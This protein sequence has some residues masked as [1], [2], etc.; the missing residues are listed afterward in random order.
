MSWVLTTDA[1]PDR[2]RGPSW[3]D[4]VGR[5]L[6]PVA[7]TPRD[8][9]FD[10]GITTDALGCLRISRIEAG[11]KRISRTPALIARHPGDH[12]A[13]G[14]Q[15]SGAATLVQDGRRAELGSGDL[16]VY[17]LARPFSLSCPQ[18]FTTHVFQLPRPLLGVADSDIRRVTGV[19]IGTG[20]GFGAVLRPFLTTLAD[21]APS[22]PPAVGQR[23][24]GHVV[25]LFATLIADRAGRDPDGA[26]DH[27]VQSVRAHI[28]RNL[29]EVSLSPESI[30]RAH[31]ISVR[32][33]HRLFEGE[34]VTVS[35]L[36]QQ[37]RLEACARELAR[38]GRVTPTVSAVARRWGFVSPSHFS[39]AFRA[40]YGLSPREWRQVHTERGEGDRQGS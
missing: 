8:E 30:A 7:V 2:D 32:Y 14:L 27:L 1:V 26:P 24:A 21:A 11:A 33:L 34:G 12:V 22:Y 17:D 25:D 39:R 16:A 19:A 37:R 13:F 6:V 29:D 15:V 38:R 4:A 23:L 18:R 10:G 31:H 28:D 5:A 9:P 36:I 35:R 3:S 20:H 40:A